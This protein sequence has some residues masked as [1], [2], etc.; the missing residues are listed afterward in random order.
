[1]HDHPYQYALELWRKAPG[2]VLGRIPIEVDWVPVR[3]ALVLDLLRR[4]ATQ[5]PG[6]LPAMTVEPIWEERTGPPAII[7]FRAVLTVAGAEASRIFAITYFRAQAQQ[8]ACRF[9]EKGQL[10][11]GEDFEYCVLAIPRRPG[12]QTPA[13]FSITQRE[14]PLPI[15][16]ASIERLMGGAILFGTENSHDLPVFFH[17]RVLEEA[18]I[19]TRR[20]GSMETGGV[21]IGHVCRDA[22]LPE[23]FL[24]ITA[25]IPARA[26]GELTRLSF[27]PDTWTAVQAAVDRRNREEIWLGWFHSHSF[28]RQRQDKTKVREASARR[29]ATPFLSEEDCRLHRVCFPRAYGIALLVTDCP[30]SGMSWTTFGWRCGDLAP[31]LPRHSRASSRRI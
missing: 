24:E 13:R 23:L 27:T 29:T 10:K 11:E 3:E 5:Q 28:Y 9:V 12:A 19:R 30:R 6:G 8:A 1:M 18:S 26:K 21:L 16:P 22:D 25:L 4:G 31:G 17:W 15:K 7:G 20:A 14:I 2:G